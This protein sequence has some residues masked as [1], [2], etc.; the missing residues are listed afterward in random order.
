MK[1]KPKKPPKELGLSHRRLVEKDLITM[2]TGSWVR[3]RTLCEHVDLRVN[4]GSLYLSFSPVTI[5]YILLHRLPV[6]SSVTFMSKLLPV[7]LSIVGRP[8]V[9]QTCLLSHH[10]FEVCIDYVSW[11]SLRDHVVG[12]KQVQVSAENLFFLGF[13]YLSF[14]DFVTED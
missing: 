14:D 4:Q 8:R 5:T 12:R 13:V 1:D 9:N 3:E 10:T 2:W 6:K 7:S 11:T